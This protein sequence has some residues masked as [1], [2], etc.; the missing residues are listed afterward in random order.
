MNW[1]KIFKQIIN[2]KN[3]FPILILGFV[4]VNGI[5]LYKMGIMVD[6]D[7]KEYLAYAEELDQ[8]GF[9]VKPHYFWYLG[10]VGFL[11]TIMKIHPSFE[12]VVMVQYLLSF[13]A[14]ISLYR[15][16]IRLTGKPI[17]GLITCGLFLGFFKIQFWNLF[18]Y[19]ES[20][21]IS[22]TCFTVYFIIKWDKNE[23]RNWEVPLMIL[24][25]LTTFFT[26][27]TGI[28]ILAA[29]CV[30][31]FWKVGGEI[32]SKKIKWGVGIAVLIVGILLL[33]KMLHTFGFVDD[34]LSGEI[35][36]NV[37]NV[38]HQDYARYLIMDRPDNLWLP[39]DN[40]PTLIRFA[41]LIVMNPWYSIKLISTKLFYF[42]FY[43]RPYYSWIHNVMALLVLL[44]MYGFF[45]MEMVKGDT[46]RSFKFFIAVFFLISTLSPVLLT[47][48]WSSRFL[49]PLL[50]LVFL[51]GSKG[52]V[53]FIES[54]SK[55]KH[56]PF[57]FHK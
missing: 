56:Q 19:A 45:I 16:A 51:L 13:L 25:I 50:P 7:T 31:L 40:H 47:V 33:N 52:M 43:V 39:D 1:N 55:R 22:L 9:F 46:N 30:L 18:L 26:K 48:D 53:R 12:A 37:T 4:L 8:N 20:L 15:S 44:P 38:S 17:V 27:P 6:A 36:Y 54:R 5:W 49:M 3:H 29:S 11:W 2:P 24:V 14:M 28:A 23:L 32:R 34:Y 57:F 42:L 10:Y 21:L 41:S 35:I